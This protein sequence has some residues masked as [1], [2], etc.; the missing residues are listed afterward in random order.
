MA[1][2]PL[3]PEEASMRLARFTARIA[4][5]SALTLTAGVVASTGT[6][7]ADNPLAPRTTFNMVVNQADGTVPAPADGE[8]I[9]N[10]DSVK[11]T[12]RAYYNA[13][14][15]ISNKTS[16]RYLDEVRGIEHHINSALRGTAP[17]NT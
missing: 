4:G 10:I 17:A 16:S 15:G 5:L 7:W 6:A 11:S 1:T 9:P 14:G 2:R 3:V 12:I 8:A 13:S